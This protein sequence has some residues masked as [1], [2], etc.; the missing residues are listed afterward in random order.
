MGID[1]WILLGVFV[2]GLIGGVV[3]AL[4]CI[5]FGIRAAN[6]AREGKAGLTP[7]YED[8]NDVDEL[9]RREKEETEKDGGQ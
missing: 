3:I 9:N 6:E 2:A 5:L 1:G 8:T 4:Y 7:A